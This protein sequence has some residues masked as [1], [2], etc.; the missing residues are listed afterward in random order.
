MHRWYLWLV[1]ILSV[2][3]TGSVIAEQFDIVNTDRYWIEGVPGIG[4]GNGNYLD[5]S[6]PPEMLMLLSGWF[7]W[8][9]HED[10]DISDRDDYNSMFGTVN[11][12]WMRPHHL[13]ETEY[14]DLDLHQDPQ[15][16]KRYIV[17][18]GGWNPVPPDPSDFCWFPDEPEDYIWDGW[19]NRGSE[20][21]QYWYDHIVEYTNTVRQTVTE[22]MYTL[23]QEIDEDY[24]LG[25]YTVDEPNPDK[26]PQGFFRIYNDAI[27]DA[28]TANGINTS[29]PIFCT[30]NKLKYCDDD[31]YENLD[32]YVGDADEGV[33]VVCVDKYPFYNLKDLPILENSNGDLESRGFGYEVY[34]PEFNVLSVPGYDDCSYENRSPKSRDMSSWIMQIRDQLEVWERDLPIISIPQGSAHKNGGSVFRHS[35]ENYKYSAYHRAPSYAELRHQVFSALACGATGFLP[36]ASYMCFNPNPPGVSW[37]R[38]P[39]S[40]FWH[41][42]NWYADVDPQSG[43]TLAYYLENGCRYLPNIA[44]ALED[45]D[46]IADVETFYNDEEEQMFGNYK[47]LFEEVESYAQLMIQGEYLDE[48]LTWEITDVTGNGASD[49]TDLNTMFIQYDE[50]YYLFAV[51]SCKPDG[52][53]YHI[54]AI[55]VRFH[56]DLT[57]EMDCFNSA[58]LLDPYQYEES[59]SFP[60][61]DESNNEPIS[62]IHDGDIAHFDVHFEPGEVHVYRFSTGIRWE[63]PTPQIPTLQVAINQTCDGDTLFI[64]QDVT[65]SFQVSGNRVLVGVG[66]PPPTLTNSNEYNLCR[67]TDYPQGGGPGVELINL[68]LSGDHNGVNLIENGG[69][70][71]LIDCILDGSSAGGITGIINNDLMSAYR[72]DFINCDTGISGYGEELNLFGCEFLGNEGVPGEAAISCASSNP[73][74]VLLDND[75]ETNRECMVKDY[76]TALNIVCADQE[77]ENEITIRNTQILRETDNTEVVF[78]DG[79]ESQLIDVLV[80]NSLL[81]LG[82][83]TTIACDELRITGSTLVEHGIGLTGNQFTIEHSIMPESS[84]DY[85]SATIVNCFFQGDGDPK[86]VDPDNSNFSLKWDSPCLDAGSPDPDLRD[87]DHTQNDIGYTRIYREVD[88]VTEVEDYTQ[89]EKGVYFAEESVDPKGFHLPSGSVLLLGSGV[90]VTVDAVNEEVML[91]DQEDAER[92]VITFYNPLVGHEH[93]PPTLKGGS[94]FV[95]G[96]QEVGISENDWVRMNHLRYVEADGNLETSYVGIESNDLRFCFECLEP[97]IEPSTVYGHFHIGLRCSGQLENSIL[98]GSTAPAQLAILG[99]DI[100]INTCEL[101][102]Y[103]YT[104]LFLFNFGQNI[105]YKLHGLIIEGEREGENALK[106]ID[107]AYSSFRL[108]ESRITYHTSYGMRTIE[109]WSDMHQVAHNRIEHNSSANPNTG[110]ISLNASNCQLDCGANRIR[111]SETSTNIPLI[112]SVSGLEHNSTDVSY[113]DWGATNPADEGILPE[114]WGDIL[115]LPLYTWEETPPIHDCLNQSIPSELF[116]LGNWQEINGEIDEAI[117]TY[118]TIVKDY[119]L[120]PFAK[121]ATFRLGYIGGKGY[122]EGMT[123]M[124]DFQE[125]LV[126]IGDVNYNLT[127][128]IQGNYWELY[129][130]LVN[131]DEAVASLEEQRDQAETESAR[132]YFELCLAYIELC[133]E[134]GGTYSAGDPV[135]AGVMIRESFERQHDYI[136]QVLA[137][138]SSEEGNSLPDNLPAE[139]SLAQNYPNPFNPVTTITYAVPRRCEL[140]LAVYNILGQ[141]VALLVEGFQQP[142]NY[143]IEF[144]GSSLAS[145]LYFYRLSTP[146]EVMNR[147]M[148]LVK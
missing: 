41:S 101:Y 7:E 137:I 47:T 3:C 66:S 143:T 77:G 61:L 120:D 65:E 87:Q 36:W 42:S 124:S 69:D 126:E 114:S 9:A 6:D 72:T 145:G 121:R 16:P 100:N 38:T 56:M 79:Y 27:R 5:N 11:T 135:Q 33:D 28:E 25:W 32:R 26:I 54:P 70:L 125:L 141:R 136:E 15:Y 98:R 53:T 29:L 30:I 86:F 119:P 122:D 68:R 91:G 19:N 133:N 99:S 39:H 111:Y 60:D 142:G 97:N 17:Y 108:S 104:G 82:Y 88:L 64:H 57:S 43:D 55:Y 10:D 74:Q 132:N 146:D 4:E 63:G 81:H 123:V 44:E 22:S 20:Y 147:K 35:D 46:L 95:G 85:S 18:I 118:N 71:V 148:L 75:P 105:E 62:F 48:Y 37:G 83:G 139:F 50:D 128:F 115:Y 138:Y 51:N 140:E 130:Q 110:Q 67:I 31:E 80:E 131:L 1:L 45:V 117:I 127:Y 94:F 106:G 34:F 103:E 49:E 89:M 40:S 52:D 73:M 12:L 107:A 144:D 14:L 59:S 13:L 21:W 113:N 116:A 2:Y 76:P 90:N 134:N 92:T 93:D 84:T 23:L 109:S 102:D 96:D 129:S 24:I 112:Q 78:I 58:Y 8:G